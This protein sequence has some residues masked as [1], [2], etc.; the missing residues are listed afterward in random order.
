MSTESQ[1]P[2]SP[3]LTPTALAAAYQVTARWYSND[4]QLIW[5]RVGLFVT[6]NT[7]LLT[8]EVFASHLHL[9]VRAVVPV[10]GAM[11]CFYWYQLVRRAWLYQDFQLGMLCKQEAALG[12]G[13]L[14]VFTQGAEFR[15]SSEM[16][17]SFRHRTLINAIIWSYVALHV[18][19]FICAVIGISFISASK[20]P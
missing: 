10:F 19:L 5:R 4:A 16:K 17:S 9:L 1:A 7:A 6:L 14:G 13:E 2:P 18:A 15:A 20:S 12:L 8:A 3:Q 11:F